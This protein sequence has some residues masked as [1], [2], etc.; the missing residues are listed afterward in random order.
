MPDFSAISAALTAVKNLIDGAV[1]FTGSLT[2]EGTLDA[3]G[4]LGSL[5]G[6]DVDVL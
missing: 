1:S 6:G 3:L 4:A 5:G 2:G